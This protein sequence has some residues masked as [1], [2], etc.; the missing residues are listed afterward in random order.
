MKIAS[1]LV[2]DCPA[3]GKL[4]R[5]AQIV[6]ALMAHAE[7]RSFRCDFCGEVRTTDGETA[8]LIEVSTVALEAS[9]LTA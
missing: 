8:T 3:C 1:L 9:G 6:P 2:V 7:I 5:P 4:M